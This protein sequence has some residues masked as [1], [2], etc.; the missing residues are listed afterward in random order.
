MKTYFDRSRLEHACKAVA[1]ALPTREIKP[2]LRN[3]LVTVSDRTALVHATN[4]ELSIRASIPTDAPVPDAAFLVPA[5]EF[6]ESLRN[7]KEQEVELCDD[8]DSVQVRMGSANYN[9]PKGDSP[10]SFPV[11]NDA[12]DGEC[13]QVSARDLFW[14]LRLTTF[15]A[16]ATEPGR[17][18]LTGVQ[19]RFDDGSI[20][21]WGSDA[22][23]MANAVFMCNGDIKPRTAVVVPA[24]AY[25]AL[26]T[27]IKEFGIKDE[28]IIEIHPSSN[29]LA[30]FSD[31]IC[32]R[33]R[34]L[35]GLYPNFEQVIARSQPTTRFE[36]P[37]DLLEC[38]VRQ[39]AVVVQAGH[40]VVLSFVPNKMS[41]TVRD[42]Y[43]GK[44]KIDVPI[45]CPQAE[46]LEF[47]GNPQLI[48]K[49][50]SVLAAE[51]YTT[52]EIGYGD[53][54]PL[55]IIPKDPGEGRTYLHVV[56]PMVEAEAA[57]A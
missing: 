29:E 44:S 33:T 20:S 14:G 57:A 9:F 43:I 4:L 25:S 26:A 50:L 31:R 32:F 40:R 48:I 36:M 28:D 5:K 1:S 52:V 34:L 47:S 38:A 51:K 45:D 30:V 42:S 37:I 19:T 16:C 12:R 41:L 3:F 8:G 53:Q 22:K 54:R 35:D 21:L 17:P 56:A 11:L 15:A 24:K 18:A 27:S 2:I 49:A 10:A 46:K 7:S 23:R 39:A 6:L 55:Y 13:C